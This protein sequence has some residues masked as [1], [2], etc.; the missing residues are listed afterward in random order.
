MLRDLDIDEEWTHEIVRR[1]IAQR[2]GDEIARRSMEAAGEG[3]RRTDRKACAPNSARDYDI[4]KHFT[5][6][7]LPWR[8]RIAF[9]PDGDIFKGIRSGQGLR[10]DR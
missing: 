7:Y 2:P 9:V 4:E 10:R 6:N 1:K 3:A 5:P 8:Q